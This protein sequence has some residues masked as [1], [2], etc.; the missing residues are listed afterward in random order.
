MILLGACRRRGRIATRPTTA[1]SSEDDNADNDDNVIAND[2]GNN[3]DSD[4]TNYNKYIDH[5]HNDHI[6]NNDN[7]SIG[8]TV[9]NLNAHY[10]VWKVDLDVG[11]TKTEFHVTKATD[12][13]VYGYA[14][15]VYLCIY[16]Y[17]YICVLYMCIYIYIYIE[18]ER[19]RERDTCIKATH[20]AVGGGI[21]RKVQ[22]DSVVEKEDPEERFI[23]QPT[24]P[25]LWR[26]VNKE[27]TGSFTDEPKGYAIMIET[28]PAVQM[29][30]DSHP[31]AKAS[32]IYIYIYIYI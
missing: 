15:M 4:D 6:H 17:I 19:E 22:V 5:N 14:Y 8:D 31:Y 7:N 32:A 11:G 24:S 26:I 20:T 25:G 29:L 23:A 12:V 2:N 3:D 13:Y 30:P 18:R 21:P 28:A 16:I 9:A 27:K 10:V 1:R